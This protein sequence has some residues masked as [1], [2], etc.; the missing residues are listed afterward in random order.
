M[1]ILDWQGE[2]PLQRLGLDAGRLV[3]EAATERTVDL[4]LVSRTERGDASRRATIGSDI[5]EIMQA[6]PC[7]LL[8]VA[9]AEQ[10]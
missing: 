4:I 8:I 3:T 2:E 5:E 1:L 9:A 10:P 6:T 7:S